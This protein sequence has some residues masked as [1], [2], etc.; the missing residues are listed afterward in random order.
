MDGGD[1]VQQVKL[2]A[3]QLT[4]ACAHLVGAIPMAIGLANLR[5][6]S[7]PLPE[8]IDALCE[9]VKQVERKPQ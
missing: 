5:Q 1:P 6:I 8:D 9:L 2:A 3:D 7:D 4:L